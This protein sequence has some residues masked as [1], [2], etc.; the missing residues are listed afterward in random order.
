MAINNLSSATDPAFISKCFVDFPI[1]CI[2]QS[3]YFDEHKCCACK[4]EN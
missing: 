3:S 2:C 4:T 1:N